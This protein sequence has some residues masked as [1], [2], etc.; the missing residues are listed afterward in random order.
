MSDDWRFE[1]EA[2]VGERMMKRFIGVTT[3][4]DF[5][6][7]DDAVWSKTLDKD[8]CYGSTA[9]GVNSFPAFKRHLRKHPELRECESVILVSR[10]VG[11]NITA[12]PEPQTP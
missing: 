10:F 8:Q 7:G 5:W 2:P 12:F 11:Y 3:Y 4:S 9:N 1:F 6:Y